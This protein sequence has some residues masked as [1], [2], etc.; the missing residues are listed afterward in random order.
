MTRGRVTSFD[1][2]KEAGVSQSAVSRAFN[3]GTSISEKTRLR[4]EAAAEKLGYRPNAMAR[5]LISRRSN[6]IGL[7]MADIV[8]PFYPAVL[9]TF[10]R[11]FQQLGH[12]VMLFMVARDQQVSDVLPQL[13]EYQVDGVVITSATL[14]PEMVEHCQRLQTPV[15][16]FNRYVEGIQADSI[17]CDNIGASRAIADLLLDAGHRQLAFIAGVRNTSTSQDREQGFFSRIHER[18]ATAPLKA[19]GHYQYQGGYEAALALFAGETKPDA[20]FCANDLMALGAIDAIRNQLKLNIPEQVSVIGFDDIKEASWKNYQLTTY[21]PRVE[22][23]VNTAVENMLERISNPERPALQLIEAGEIVI[24]Q[25]AR[26]PET[27]YQPI[28]DER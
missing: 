15:T 26:L 19:E 17:C 20:I 4:V 27:I 1:V 25:T 23:M 13:L 5:T 3:S 24:R 16:L 28:V 12:R 10:M 22:K 9:D 14:S 7:V 6:M 21:R 11:S 8:N 18:R 2:A